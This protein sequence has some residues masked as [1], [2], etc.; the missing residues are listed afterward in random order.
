MD[1]LTTP[2]LPLT[3]WLSVV[4]REYLSEFLPAGGAAVKFAILDDAAIETAAEHLV[5]LGQA[6]A[7]LTVPIEAGRTRIHLM[8]ELFFAIARALKI[9]VV[10]LVDVEPGPRV[11]LDGLKL[12]PPKTGRKPSR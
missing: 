8:H 6:H 7:M 12:A 5:R 3:E 9:K 10:D 2:T 1:V 11:D 4:E